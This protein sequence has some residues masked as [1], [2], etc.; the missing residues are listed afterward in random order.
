[1]LTPSKQKFVDIAAKTYG[2]GAILTRKQIVD[3]ALEN[4]IPNPSW[5]K[6]NAYK[7]VDCRFEIRD[8]GAVLMSFLNIPMTT[9]I[10]QKIGL[11]LCAGKGP[12][13]GGNPKHRE[14]S[15]KF[16]NQFMVEHLLSQ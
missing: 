10:R 15:F 4:N 1:M 3:V 13:M 12:T 16:A 14:A 8:D 2:E 9:P 6:K 11:G 7:T 5:I